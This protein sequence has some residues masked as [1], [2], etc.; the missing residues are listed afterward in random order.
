MFALI[1]WLFNVKI[2]TCLQRKK[3]LFAFNIKVI[4]RSVQ[5]LLFALK[6]DFA[7]SL[8]YLGLKFCAIFLF[9]KFSQ[10]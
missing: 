3:L 10:C 1:F 8:I 5:K 4:T 2:A 6:Q 9:K 7:H